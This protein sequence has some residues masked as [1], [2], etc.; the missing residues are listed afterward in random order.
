MP[1][2]SAKGIPQALIDALRYED[3]A[4]YWKE[5]RGKG[6]G[7]CY[8]GDA[9][10]YLGKMG[11]NILSWK[12]SKYKASRVIWAMHHGDTSLVIDHINR[13]KADDR[14]ENLR[15]VTQEANTFN[16]GGGVRWVAERNKWVIS[17]G[18]KYIGITPDLF[19]AWCIRKSLEVSA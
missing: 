5:T 15:A 4:L 13:N 7:T 2:T 1:L 18:H 19:E 16:Q 9:A 6:G 3:G 12:R 11:Y 8:A 14:I 17:W 10:T